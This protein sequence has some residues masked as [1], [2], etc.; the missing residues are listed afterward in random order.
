MRT[1]S[2]LFWPTRT[3]MRRAA[4]R[5]AHRLSIRVS[6]VLF[7]TVVASGPASAQDRIGAAGEVIEVANPLRIRLA[8]GASVPIGATVYTLRP[9]AGGEVGV[10]S[11]TYTVV[12]PS[13]GDVLVELSGGEA[14]GSRP[15][16]GDRVEVEPSGRPSLL[17]IESDPA[18]A[19]VSR[20]GYPLGATPLRVHVVPGPHAFVLSAPGYDPAPLAV[21][22]PEGELVSEFQSLSRPPPAQQ[23]FVSAEIA[24]QNGDYAATTAFL[25]RA[26]ENTDASLT[27]A[28][29]GS[30]PSLAFAARVGAGIAARG[31]GRGLTLAQT[32]SAVSKIRFVHERRSRPEARGAL[33]EIEGILTSDPAVAELRALVGPAPPTAP[34]P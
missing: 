21:Q 28:Q 26:A 25:T 8:V 30:L 12:Q 15:G 11:G 23:L 2:A 1:C 9:V 31:P 16:V 5:V 24:F 20:A 6:R 18:G 29:A 32:L 22:V 34:A 3:G 7:W 13:G 19:L 17:L 10:L 27:A 33:A 4:S 14:S